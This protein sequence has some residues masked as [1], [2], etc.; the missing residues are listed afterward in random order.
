MMRAL[1]VATSIVGLLLGAGFAVAWRYAWMIHGGVWVTYSA[2]T[3]PGDLIWSDTSGWWP[4]V[5]IAPGLGT[6][7]GLALG[8][9]SHR[10]GWRL[11][12]T[13]A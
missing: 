7:V 5:V 3:G 1:L 9:L 8:W 12:R 2:G 4:I 6:I 10:A 11:T 13:Q